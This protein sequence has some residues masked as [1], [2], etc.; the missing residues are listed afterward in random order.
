[1]PV[2]EY[3]CAECSKQFEVR[4]GFHDEDKAICPVCEGDGKRM[5]SPVTVIYKGSGFYSTDYGRGNSGPSKRD[6]GSESDTEAKPAEAKE[7]KKEAPKADSKNN[8]SK[9]ST[10]SKSEA[11]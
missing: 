9:A 11:N 10:D 8:G 3:E 7:T 4:R 6:N 1:M 2:Y 5:F